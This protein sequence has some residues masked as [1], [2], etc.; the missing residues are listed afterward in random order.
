MKPSRRVSATLNVVAF[1][2]LASGF[3][4]NMMNAFAADSSSSPETMNASTEATVSVV[5]AEISLELMSHG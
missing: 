3:V 4:S 5:A 1:A 2:M